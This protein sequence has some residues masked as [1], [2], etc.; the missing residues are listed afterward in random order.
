VVLEVLAGYED[1]GMAKKGLSA[2][3]QSL[4]AMQK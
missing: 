3:F 4:S 1:N 2:E